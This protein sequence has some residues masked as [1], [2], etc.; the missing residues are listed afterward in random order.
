MVQTADVGPR[1]DGVGPGPLFRSLTSGSKKRGLT[2]ISTTAEFAV[3]MLLARYVAA[4]PLKVHRSQ[5]PT[6]LAL[7][8]IVWVL[9]RTWVVPKGVPLLCKEGRGEVEILP[10]CPNHG[11]PARPSLW[12]P[13]PLLASP[14]YR[15]GT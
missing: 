4:S 9:G 13:L 7:P 11:S 6:L 15:L 14:L 3:R 8:E 2:G 5:S 1:S 12:M 10:A